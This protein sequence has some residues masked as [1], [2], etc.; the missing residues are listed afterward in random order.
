MKIR[1]M[2]PRVVASLALAVLLIPA[3]ALAL[4]QEPAPSPEPAQGLGAIHFAGISYSLVD[5][6][7]PALSIARLNKSQRK[8]ISAARLAFLLR[9]TDRKSTRL[10]SSH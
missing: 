6:I 4:A 10:N 8:R 2:L 7:R 3:N 9:R 5:K 1:D